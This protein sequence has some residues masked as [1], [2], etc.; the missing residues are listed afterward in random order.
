[1]ASS[2]LA[3]TLTALFAEEDLDELRLT[4]EEYRQPAIQFYE[5]HGFTRVQ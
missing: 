4:V 3:T 5:K 1:M 2:R